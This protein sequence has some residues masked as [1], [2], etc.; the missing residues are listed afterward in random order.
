MKLIKLLPLLLLFTFLNSNVYAA[1]DCND[2]KGNI[3]GKI[4]CKAKDSRSNSTLSSGSS[5]TTTSEPSGKKGI[6]SKI[7]QRPE[8]TKRKNNN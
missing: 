8:W 3:V 7:W 4:F 5:T 6:L 1:Q 2:I